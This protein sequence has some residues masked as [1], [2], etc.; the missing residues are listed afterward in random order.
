MGRQESRA[1][2]SG[3]PP[4]NLRAMGP[5]VLFDKSFLQS[6]TLDESVIFDHFFISVISP[7]FYVETLADLEKPAREGKKPEDEVR[8]IAEKTPEAHAYPCVNRT[9]L[10]LASLMGRGFPTRFSVLCSPS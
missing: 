1:L 9:D 5:A 4:P 8:V 2:R 7:L 10:C 6:L 3:I